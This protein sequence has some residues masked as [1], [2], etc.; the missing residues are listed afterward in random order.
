MRQLPS[1]NPYSGQS[2]QEQV[3]TYVVNKR[4]PR[5]ETLDVKAATDVLGAALGAA[6][7][8]NVE[9]A[10][11]QIAELQPRIQELVQE[12]VAQGKRPDEIDALLED[13]R[14]GGGWLLGT[15]DIREKMLGRS[16]GEA[17]AAHLKARVTTNLKRLVTDFESG[18]TPAKTTPQQFAAQATQAIEAE[19]QGLRQTLGENLGALTAFDEQASRL[20]ADAYAEV[21]SAHDRA[22]R[23]YLG[24]SAKQE[25]ARTFSEWSEMRS[26]PAGSA[27]ANATAH[28]ALQES[29]AKLL[30]AYGDKETV[31]KELED[32]VIATA[33]SLGS[34]EGLALINA[35]QT[36]E[37]MVGDESFTGESAAAVLGST[38]LDSTSRFLQDQEPDDSEEMKERAYKFVNETWAQRLMKPG[39]SYDER[40]ALEGEI[41]QWAYDNADN[42]NAR[43]LNDAVNSLLGSAPRV[44]N[45]EVMAQI[46]QAYDTGGDLDRSLLAFLPPEKRGETIEA[47]RRRDSVGAAVSQRKATVSQMAFFTE[48]LTDAAD[49]AAN[50]GDFRTAAELRKLS[51]S[52]ETDLNDFI[53]KESAKMSGPDD[54]SISDQALDAGDVYLAQTIQPQVER[55]IA[56]SREDNNRFRTTQ[57][58]LRQRVLDGQQDYYQ[59]D[60]RSLSTQQA[61]ELRAAS[62]E[63]HQ[64]RELLAARLH[65]SEQYSDMYDTQVGEM[66]VGMDAIM[67]TPARKR[68][69]QAAL[70]G[71][72]ETVILG[73]QFDQVP[74]LELE[75]KAAEEATKFT[76][77]YFKGFAPV[78]VPEV[79]DAVLNAETASFEASPVL[80][81]S[82]DYMEFS[83]KSNFKAVMQA[84]GLEKDWNTRTRLNIF[85]RPDDKRVV[86]DYKGIPFDI[87]EEFF[88]ERGRTPKTEGLMMTFVADPRVNPAIF[89]QVVAGEI[90]L[91]AKGE[92]EGPIVFPRTRVT[93]EEA[94]G[95][96]IGQTL[97]ITAEAR[98]SWKTGIFFSTE[99]EAVL[100]LFEDPSTRSVLTDEGQVFLQRLLGP[101]YDPDNKVVLKTVLDHIL[102]NVESFEL[103]EQGRADPEDYW[104]RQDKLSKTGSYYLLPYGIR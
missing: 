58:T 38:A 91:V 4:T 7:T 20:R 61:D 9:Q 64:V 70:R 34:S 37:V 59:L 90:P 8:A 94:A 63:R 11:Q 76:E 89:D 102:S 56:R 84:A 43:A 21:A 23:G 39:M 17:T 73:P 44:M 78:E 71:H 86:T 30:E 53:A 88:G 51:G 6:R 72:M 27:N 19:V 40:T 28:K 96:P 82:V 83:S 35:Y 49:E 14:T 16:L 48:Q 62:I 103:E 68:E 100:K 45:D 93:S 12:A 87:A 3:R 65:E 47:F 97:K 46:Q 75:A 10:K 85:G 25:L 32:T 1:I 41:R 74:F 26:D 79:D 5:F 77:N 66:V 80:D 92:E 50:N 24:R 36:S 54:W 101:D 57:S 33:R 98:P 15:N 13:F 55:L 29:A 31:L 81:N 22:M 69:F 52:I 2:L 18:N 104:Q 95:K 60:V 42:Q 99:R 67:G